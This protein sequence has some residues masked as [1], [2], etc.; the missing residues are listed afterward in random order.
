MNVIRKV[1]FL[2]RTLMFWSRNAPKFI[3]RHSVNLSSLRIFNRSWQDASRDC[4]FQFLCSRCFL[5]FGEFRS[6]PSLRSVSAASE[7]HERR[8]PR[9]RPPLAA[10]LRPPSRRDLAGRRHRPTSRPSQSLS[11]RSLVSPFA[12]LLDARAPAAVVASP[13]SRGGGAL[14]GASLRR[15]FRAVPRLL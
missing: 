13:A 8:A 1:K 9:G 14:A 15:G 5:F 6:R 2:R 10:S 11:C 12:M 4:R 7:P 3:G